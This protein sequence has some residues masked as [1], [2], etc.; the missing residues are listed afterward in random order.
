MSERLSLQIAGVTVVLVSGEADLCVSV[1][2]IAERFRIDAAEADV[3]LSAAWG[4]PPEGVADALVFDAGGHWQLYQEGTSL[5]FQ[6]VAP[7]LGPF[8]Y[9]IARFDLEFT[10]GE[11]RLNRG[12]FA[13]GVPLSPLD[14]PLDELLLVNYL[15]A[16]RGIEVHACGVL[17]AAGRGHVFA[18]H[19][20]AGKTTLARLLAGREGLTILSDDRIILRGTP[21][22]PWIYGTPWHGEA[23]L[24]SPTGG[25]LAGVYFLQHGLR[26][27][28]TPVSRAAA[29]A[30]LFARAFPPL[31]RREALE[32]AIGFCG[33]VAVA[34]PCQ[35]LDFVPDRRVVDFV[36][37]DAAFS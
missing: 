12:C 37:R 21:S 32:F 8:P 31:Y 1:A 4:G 23:E 33:E 14:Y 36:L 7:H 24:A 17:D 22:G 15:A 11:I 5:S 2:G 3:T 26:N 30:S 34:V 27:A 28:L 25:P 35:A 19:S 10:R 20:G 29:A 16:G 18:G 13:P 9:K 6:F